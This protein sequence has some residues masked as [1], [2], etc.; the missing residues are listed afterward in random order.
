MLL[1]MKWFRNVI[2]FLGGA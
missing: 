1:V 2:S